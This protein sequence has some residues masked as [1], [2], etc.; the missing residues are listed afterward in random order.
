MLLTDIPLLNSHEQMG[1][2]CGNPLT[3]IYNDCS[4]EKKQILAFVNNRYAEIFW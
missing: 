2:S 3:E 1:G 4:P